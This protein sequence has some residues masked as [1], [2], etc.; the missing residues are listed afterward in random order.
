MSVS[1]LKTAAT[2]VRKEAGSGAAVALVDSRVE[3]I[4]VAAKA[5]KVAHGT[6]CQNC[7]I[8]PRRFLSVLVSYML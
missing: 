3:E 1:Q 4:G 2:K 7:H 5:W 8:R 6:P